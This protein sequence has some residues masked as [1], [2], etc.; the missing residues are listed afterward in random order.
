MSWTMS[1]C[2]LGKLL[3]RISMNR[4]MSP[5]QKL[6]KRPG[7]A[8]EFVH[9]GKCLKVMEVSVLRLSRNPFLNRL[10]FGFHAT[11]DFASDAQGQL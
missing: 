5:T 4:G 1:L 6:G 3:R 9:S 2:S 10:K 8:F 11:R 7:R